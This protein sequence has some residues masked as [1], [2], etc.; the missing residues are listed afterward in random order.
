MTNIKVYVQAVIKDKNGK[1]TQVTRKRLCHSYV[2]PFIYVLGGLMNV[3]TVTIVDTGGTSR[4]VVCLGSTTIVSF[5][6]A[7][8]GAG[9]IAKGIVVGTDNTPVA[10]T[11]TKLGTIILNGTTSTK[12]SYGASSVGG[13]TI[14]GSTANFIL[15]RTFTNSSGANITVNEVALYAQCQIAAGTY[16]YI[17]LDRTL[18]TFTINN[19][20]SGTLT[21]TI[22]ATV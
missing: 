11:D 12:L 10:I 14:A 6:Y 2:H 13:P 18:L 20:S 19:G 4:A 7:V 15:A 3:G 21:Y 1:I 5:L 8:A 9:D 22:S 16:V 17:C